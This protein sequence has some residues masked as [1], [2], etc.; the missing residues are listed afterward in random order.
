MGYVKFS[1]TLKHISLLK[2]LQLMIRYNKLNEICV[3]KIFNSGINLTL[4]LN[5]YERNCLND[6]LYKNKSI[7]MLRLISIEGEEDKKMCLKEL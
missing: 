3:L 5:F 2:K 4:L 6:K 1:I 7:Y